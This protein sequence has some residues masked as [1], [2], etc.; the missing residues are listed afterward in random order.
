VR[1]VQLLCD[2]CQVIV[3][4]EQPPCREA[5]GDHCPE[6]ACTRCGDAILL[7]P[8]TELM[9]RRPAAKKQGRRAA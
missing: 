3:R 7:A 6:W 8:V 5:H 2:L 1:N 4:F 9:R